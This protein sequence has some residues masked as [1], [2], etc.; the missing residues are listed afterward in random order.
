MNDEQ[1]D[2]YLKRAP[3]TLYGEMGRTADSAFAQHPVSIPD[4][5]PA[6]SIRDAAVPIAAAAQVDTPVEVLDA[7]A[8]NRRAEDAIA[9]FVMIAVWGTI[10]FGGLAATSLVWYWPLAAGFVAG[11]IVQRLLVGPLRALLVVARWAIQLALY[12]ALIMGVLALLAYLR[13]AP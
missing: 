11:W 6:R 7:N 9:G 5:R 8:R 10:A 1:W 2:D 3:H 12:A 4:A 13:N